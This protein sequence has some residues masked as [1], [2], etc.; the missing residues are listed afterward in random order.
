MINLNKNKEE[1]SKSFPLKEVGR[2][3]G[4][5]I[6]IIGTLGGFI[7]NS[8]IKSKDATIET[9]KERLVSKDEQLND[10]RKRLG[11]IE[12]DQ[13]SY[14][15]LTNNELKLKALKLVEQIRQEISNYKMKHDKLM[16]SDIIS[17]NWN[18]YNKKTSL[19]STEL[20]N[21]FKN[22]Y[23]IE[24]IILKDEILSRLSYK[25]KSSRDKYIDL[26]YEHPTNPLGVEEIVDDLETISKIL[27]E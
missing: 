4:A 14:S 7:L 20:M 23:K 2:A 5:T 22:K 21:N 8:T 11:I 27:L 10:Y 15:V 6:I 1:K 13:T 3:I 24:A 16:Y 25:L 12:E 9:L 26:H 18:E 19:I 17:K